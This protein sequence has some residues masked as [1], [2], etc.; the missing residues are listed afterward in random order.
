MNEYVKQA[1]DFLNKANAKCEIVYGGISRNETWKETA[2]RNWYDVTITTSRG[3]MS[4][5][6]WDSINNTEISQ[7]TLEEYVEKKL[8]RRYSDFSYDER[9]KAERE[10]KKLKTKA[11]PSEYDVLACLEKYDVGTFEDFCSEFG[12][13]EDSRTAERIYIAVIKEY[14][15]LTRIFTEEQMEELSEIQ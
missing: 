5:V 2:K 13:D 9:K 12:Y 6:F 4:Y 3:K 15:D 11:V 14:K 8:K 1:K 7:M 10:L